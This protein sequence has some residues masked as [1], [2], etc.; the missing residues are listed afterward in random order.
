MLAQARSEALD[1]S[2]FAR[3][4]GVSKAGHPVVCISV[5]RIDQIAQDVDMVSMIELHLAL[6]HVAGVEGVPVVSGCVG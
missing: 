3:V 6:T 2:E 1:S 4:S 5:A